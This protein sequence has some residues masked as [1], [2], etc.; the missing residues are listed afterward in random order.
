VDGCCGALPRLDLTGAGCVA[1]FEGPVEVLDGGGCFCA[2]IE[3]ILRF[4]LVAE[5]GETEL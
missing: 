5:D 4:G 3:L 1:G 2:W